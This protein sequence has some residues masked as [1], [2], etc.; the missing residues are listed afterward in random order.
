MRVIALDAAT[1]EGGAVSLAPIEQVADE[2]IRH[3]AT[4]TEALQQRVAGAQVLI[5]NK[6]PL[7]AAA[8]DA[9]PDLA[10]VCIA[11]TGTNVVD[12][13]AAAERG[14][15]VCNVPGYA[16]QAVAQYTLAL[17]MALA[18]RWHESMRLVHAGAWSRAPNF[19][20]TDF[21]S[22]ELEG[23]TLGVVGYGAIGRRFARMAAGVGMRVLVAE[24]RG[25]APREGRVDFDEM[26]ARV[27]V[28]SLH[29]PLTD[30]THGLIGAAELAAL[31]PQGWLINTARGALVDEMALAQALRAGTLGAAALDV[32]SDEPP[33]PKHPLLAT[34][35]P[36]L[37]VTPHC[38]WASD[39]ARQRLVD[40]IAA[41]IR[42]FRGGECLNRVEQVLNDR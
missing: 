7:G 29:C 13:H 19:C 2:L 23:R 3:P 16:T 18:T 27:D 41:N 11:A 39:Q 34:D 8:M 12:L 9:A 1:L 4:S 24:R 42:A 14:I 21:P 17:L 40:V 15:A 22:T 20:L 6:V 26:L 30:E 25:A 36:R 31:G 10:L 38:A 35:L 32:I 28:L 37:L 33:P 5:T